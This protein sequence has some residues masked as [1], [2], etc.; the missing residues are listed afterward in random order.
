MQSDYIT[1]RQV[2]NNIRKINI[3]KQFCSD[4]AMNP[5]R[6]GLDAKKA[7]DSVSHAFIESFLV[8][9]KM[10]QYFIKI[11]RLLY[12]DVQSCVLIND[13]M[14][15]VEDLFIRVMHYIMY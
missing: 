15:K 14:T 6:I 1:V 10:L 13:F 7:F 11:F 5:V 9:Y 8:K 12:N 4:S 2:H 3:V